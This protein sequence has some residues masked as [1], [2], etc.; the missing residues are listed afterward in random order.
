MLPF[1]FMIRHAVVHH[2]AAPRLGG[3]CVPE[4]SA[5]LCAKTGLAAFCRRHLSN[6]RGGLDVLANYAEDREP[7]KSPVKVPPASAEHRLMN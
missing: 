7:A 1:Q 6:D 3:G 4:G 5:H 2:C